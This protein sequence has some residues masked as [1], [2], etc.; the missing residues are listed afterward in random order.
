MEED[1][2]DLPEFVLLARYGKDRVGVKDKPVRS[3]KHISRAMGI[4]ETKV[5]VL[6]GKADKRLRFGMKQ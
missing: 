3:V 4:S 2:D 5:N 6:L 1:Q